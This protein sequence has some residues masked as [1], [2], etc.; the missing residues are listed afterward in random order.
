MILEMFEQG[1]SFFDY[2]FPRITNHNQNGFEHKN[3]V[4]VFLTIYDLTFQNILFQKDVFECF[5][6]IETS[7]WCIFFYL[8][9][10]QNIPCITLSS[11][12][13]SI[14]NF[15]TIKFSYTII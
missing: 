11:D 3:E 12:Q 13:L 6:Y 10:Y 8:F 9:F 2:F 15:G 1:I 7:F 14:R 5:G 4:K